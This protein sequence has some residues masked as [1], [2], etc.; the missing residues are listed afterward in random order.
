MKHTVETKPISN[1]LFIYNHLMTLCSLLTISH[2][3]VTLF[4]PEPKA[5]VAL[6]LFYNRH[7]YLVQ[8][9][10]TQMGFFLGLRGFSLSPPKTDDKY[11][12]HLWGAN[13]LSQHLGDKILCAVCTSDI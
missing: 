8:Y 4:H 10:H 12:T 3:Y 5:D 11:K 2:A 1:L 13:S 6:G 7:E 9:I